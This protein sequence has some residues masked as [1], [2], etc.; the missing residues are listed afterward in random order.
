[1]KIHQEVLKAEKQ[2]RKF[3]RKTPIEFSPYLSK[4]CNCN[5]YLKLESEQLTGSFKIRGAFNKLLSCKSELNNGFITAYTGNHGKA[6]AYVSKMLNLKGTVYV[7][8]KVSKTKLE[9]IVPRQLNVYRL[10]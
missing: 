1:M 9:A 5:V 4:L 7:P 2:I 8:K 3:I 10:S 6:V